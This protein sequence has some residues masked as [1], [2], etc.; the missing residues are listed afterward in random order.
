MKRE[1]IRSQRLKTLIHCQLYGPAGA[2]DGQLALRTKITSNF[3]LTNQSYVFSETYPLFHCGLYRLHFSKIIQTFASAGLMP[4]FYC[5]RAYSLSSF[6]KLDCPG[7]C[8]IFEDCPDNLQA[9]FHGLMRCPS[10]ARADIRIRRPFIQYVSVAVA[11]GPENNAA[12]LHN[13][14]V[15]QLLR[16]IVSSPFQ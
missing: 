16:V 6:F 3:D 11:P 8:R 9:L 2:P 7:I 12:C 5:Y 14:V 1:I 15:I 10:G 13:S 4:D